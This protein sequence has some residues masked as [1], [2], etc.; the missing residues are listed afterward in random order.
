MEES[1]KF[2]RIEWPVVIKYKTAEEPRTQ[3]QIVGKDISEGGARFVVYERLMKGT[4]LEL[5]LEVPFDSMPISARGNVAWIRKIGEENE[6]KFEIGV[7][8][9]E[10]NPRDQKRFKMYLEEEVKKRR[11]GSV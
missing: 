1:R 2:V 7:I 3:D 4:G 6:K 10:I 9:T 11:S 5:Q 8:F